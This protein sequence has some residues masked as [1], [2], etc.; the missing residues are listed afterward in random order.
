MSAEGIK[1]SQQLATTWQD[2][3]VN[4]VLAK[5]YIIRA[6]LLAGVTLSDFYRGNKHFFPEINYLPN[7]STNQVI[8]QLINQWNPWNTA[9][10]EKLAGPQPM[11]TCP[12]SQKTQRCIATFTEVH[13]MPLSSAR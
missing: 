3:S 9:L 13:Y 12:A 5:G 6:Q 4:N 2:S 10:L 8:K 1:R 11:N 7:W